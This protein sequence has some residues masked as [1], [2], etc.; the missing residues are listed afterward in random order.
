M[1]TKSNNTKRTL[2]A[3]VCSMILC[4]AMLIGSTFAWFTD[5]ASTAVNK[6]QSG[7]LDVALEM[8]D[9]E[10]NWV[11]AEGKTLE[12][13]KAKG[14]AED[15]KVLWEPGCTYEL[16]AVH[17]K[18]NG[19]LALK[20]KI[21]ISGIV[22]DAGLLK[23]IDFTYGDLDVNAEGYLEAGM[24]SEAITIKG[25]MKEEA[26][27]EYQNL[28]IEGIGITVVATQNTV[29]NDSYGNQYDKNAEYPILI[30]KEIKK[31]ANNLLTEEIVLGAESTNAVSENEPVHVTVP[32]NTV[33]KSDATDFT[34][35]IESTTKYPTIS[36][37]DNF[38]EIAYKIEM[39]LADTNTVPVPVTMFIGNNKKLSAVYHDENQM[40][41]AD[42]GAADTYQYDSNSGVITM[43]ITHCSTFSFVYQNVKK[44]EASTQDEL[45]A[46]IQDNSGALIEVNWTGTP[47]DFGMFKPGFVV[48]KNV[49]LNAGDKKVVTSNSGTY[50]NFEVKDGGVLTVNASSS[51]N[52]SGYN[53]WGTIATWIRVNGSNSRLVLN[54]GSYSTSFSHAAITAEEGGN[55]M[56]TNGKYS[57]SGAGSSGT[58]AYANGTITAVSGSKV[59]VTGGA[60]SC[61]GYQTSLFCSDGA[62]IIVENAQLDSCNGKQFAV[63]NGG[64]IKVSKTAF[65][66]KPTSTNGTVREEG[67]YWVISAAN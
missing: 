42:T 62:L 26:G 59:I 45:T 25:H 43:Y 20:Y 33:I 65:S 14:A 57:G 55:V 38:K 64:I 22:G 12:W 24:T 21:V 17:I 5:N 18:N 34:L 13:I 53:V 66:S 51:V 6:I 48:T 49:T 27:N 3:S 4:V 29:E 36:I 50:P 23:V 11:D 40:T 2:L 67:N 31:D 60:F 16:P 32:E 8:Q 61:S 39:P 28:S 46:A 35:R 54:G 58:P 1:M 63:F 7:T 41:E 52:A 19:N 15:E 47:I 30:T 10:G 44:V 9:A 37:D 56:I